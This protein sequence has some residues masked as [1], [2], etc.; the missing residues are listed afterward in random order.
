M[1]KSLRMMLSL[2]VVFFISGCGSDG[3][4]DPAPPV[5][6]TGSGESSAAFLE[7]IDPYLATSGSPTSIIM[8]FYG[9]AVSTNADC[10]N[11]TV[12]FDIESNPQ[13]FNLLTSPRLFAGNL[14]NGTYNCVIMQVSDLIRYKVNGVAVNAHAGCANTTTEYTH[15][16]YRT[17]NTGALWHNVDGQD[18]PVSG[19]MGNPVHNKVDIVAT[20]NTGAATGNGFHADQVVSLASALVVPGSAV[21]YAD[22][23][24]GIANQISGG[25]DYCVLEDGGF[26]FR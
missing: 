14:A 13:E 9:V 12:V 4:L 19:A 8:K 15:D 26:G 18:I 16:I 7:A 20:T 5:T 23:R 6:I 11:A 22:F 17:D 24:N 25:T 21:F 10:S 2:V 1:N 3:K